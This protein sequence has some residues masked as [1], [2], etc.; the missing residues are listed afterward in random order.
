MARKVGVAGARFEAP[1][2]P[3]H[4][5]V[6]SSAPIR[7]TAGRHWRVIEDEQRAGGGV[8]MEPRVSAADPKS[9]MFIKW[10]TV[11]TALASCACRRTPPPTS[12]PGVEAAGLALDEPGSGPGRIFEAVDRV[13]TRIAR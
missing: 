6:R 5:N 10:L 12:A 11:Q 9:I 13:D 1:P 7:P 4:P 2:E 3:S 8:L